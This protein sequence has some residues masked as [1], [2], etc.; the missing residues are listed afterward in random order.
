VAST[1]LRVGLDPPPPFSSLPPGLLRRVGNGALNALTG[2]LQRAFLAAL[3]ADYAR[4]SRDAAWR[5]E[6][7]K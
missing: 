2:V 7:A 3:A 6:R 5:T 4:W 1:D